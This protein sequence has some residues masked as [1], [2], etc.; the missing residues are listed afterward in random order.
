[1]RAPQQRVEIH[2][3]TVWT[4]ST[5]V[6]PFA[7]SNSRYTR[8]KQAERGHPAPGRVVCRQDGT[9]STSFEQRAI[10]LAKKLHA[11]GLSHRKIAS[12]TTQRGGMETV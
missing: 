7:S 3:T 10:A 8:A 6:G 4:I 12:S 5:L 2:L 1:M 9:S 11:D